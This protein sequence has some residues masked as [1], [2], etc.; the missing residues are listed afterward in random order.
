MTELDTAICFLQSVTTYSVSRDVAKLLSVKRWIEERDDADFAER[1]IASMSS[2]G[3]DVVYGLKTKQFVLTDDLWHR[4]PTVAYPRIFSSVLAC[5]FHENGSLRDDYDTVAVE[6]VLHIV[7]LFKRAQIPSLAKK[8]AQAAKASF[9]ANQVFALHRFFRPKTAKSLKRLWANFIGHFEKHATLGFP[10]TGSTLDECKPYNPRF[11]ILNTW[12]P[13]LPSELRLFYETAFEKYY[14]FGPRDWTLHPADELLPGIYTLDQSPTLK[15]EVVPKSA[16][17]GRFITVTSVAHTIV[18]A[19]LRESLRS[20]WR[21]LGLEEKLNIHD[22]TLSHKTLLD[23]YDRV[24]TIDLKDG[25]TCFSVNLNRAILPEPFQEFL[26]YQD[27][28]TCVI[29]GE[30]YPVTTQLMGDASSVGILTTNLYL[31]VCLAVFRTR[32]AKYI[33]RLR[34]AARKQTRG[35]TIDPVNDIMTGPRV[36]ELFEFCREL[37]I[38]IV[39]DDVILPREYE[40]EFRQVLL[41]LG[42][43]INERKS[44]DGDSPYKESCGI[45]V[46]KRPDG[47]LHRIYPFRHPEGNSQA[48]L[49]S[50]ASRFLQKVSKSTFIVELTIALSETIGPLLER[51]SYT[52]EDIGSPI[53]T[54]IPRRARA[55]SRQPVRR[56]S[57]TTAYNFRLHN[58]VTPKNRQHSFSVTEIAPS[59]E[60]IQDEALLL[61]GHSP[62][63][64]TDR[65]NRNIYGRSSR[66]VS[67]CS[68]RVAFQRL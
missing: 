7:S 13:S 36:R 22:Q 25:S 26:S 2:L 18:G 65:S 31:C 28:S 57:D 63:P 33:D 51:E 48:Y 9:I 6:L 24:V 19:S 50:T 60:L 4:K 62:R 55:T 37:P 10:G 1:V 68:F 45:W 49:Y 34:A 21:E 47:S 27:G 35:T 38:Q 8:A 42:I 56:V 40:A 15:G 11:S 30:T 59:E 43:T 52:C 16:L 61:G 64:R 32:H 54:G 66:V 46:L 17:I 41:E 67:D 23:H 3:S 20:R 5:V 58:Y 53:G 29:D 14:G 44:S 39:G 12:D